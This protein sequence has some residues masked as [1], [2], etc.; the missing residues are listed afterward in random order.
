MTL[1]APTSGLTVQNRSD[2]TPLSSLVRPISNC[3]A[4]LVHHS[5]R[6]ELRF[7]ELRLSVPLCQRRQRV[8]PGGSRPSP[9]PRAP[10]A[11]ARLDQS[12]AAQA[13]HGGEG[14][15]RGD[16]RAASG[17]QCL[18]QG[19]R[20]GVRARAEVIGESRVCSSITFRYSCLEA[21]VNIRRDS[22]HGCF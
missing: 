4:V 2:T 10:S 13:R 12:Q 21:G 11:A 22:D 6:P 14:E 1:P 3:A 20:V 15:E 8:T 16:E 17:A 5:F 9:P 7:P 18:I 19:S